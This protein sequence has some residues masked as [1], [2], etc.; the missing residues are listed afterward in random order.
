MHDLLKSL[1]AIQDALKRLSES[2]V[3]A[4]GA[5]FTR[6]ERSLPE[7]RERESLLRFGIFDLCAVSGGHRRISRIVRTHQF[8]NFSVSAGGTRGGG[9]GETR[10]SQLYFERYATMSNGFKTYTEQQ[11]LVTGQSMPSP[12]TVYPVPPSNR[13]LGPLP[14]ARR[15]LFL[16]T[17]S[18]R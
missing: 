8:E 3:E 18:S 1:P 6:R 15:I 13:K 7:A 2:G 16:D 14:R 5:I 10:I 11:H 17:I 4:R 12:S 9:S